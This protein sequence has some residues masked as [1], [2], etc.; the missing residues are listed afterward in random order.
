MDVRRTLGGVAL[1]AVG[2]WMLG[3]LAALVGVG[4]EGQLLGSD[5]QL[6]ALA[7]VAFTAASLAAYAA[8]GRPWRDTGTPYW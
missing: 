8:L 3:V 6:A 2:I 1:V 7:A 5:R 4:P